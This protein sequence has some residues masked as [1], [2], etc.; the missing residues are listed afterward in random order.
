[1]ADSCII[2]TSVWREDDWF[3]ELETDA[4]LLWLWMQTNDHS[5]KP[6]Q[7]VN[8]RDIEFQTGI[9]AM[10]L[11]ALFIDFEK[12]ER[13]ETDA[14]GHKF[15]IFTSPLRCAKCGAG[16]DLT[17]DHIVP[18]SKGGK[19]DASNLQWLCRTCNSAK[20]NRHSARY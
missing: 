5:A 9:S 8:P 12:A 3:S 4:K 14:N 11:G 2:E 16:H 19:N 7:P 18:R 6:W 20:G 17:V 1:M 13:I 10:R 15:R